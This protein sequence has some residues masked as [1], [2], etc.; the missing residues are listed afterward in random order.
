MT[1]HFKV[2]H[3]FP[4]DSLDLAENFCRN[5]TN[6]TFGPWCFVNK[7]EWEYCDIP[8]CSGM[9]DEEKRKEKKSM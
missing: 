4:D 2:P 3:R 1:H 9:Y 8:K 6:K 7:N 5:P